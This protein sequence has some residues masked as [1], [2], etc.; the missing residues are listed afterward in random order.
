MQLVSF[1]EDG[2]HSIRDILAARHLEVQPNSLHSCI[3]QICVR[4]CGH[5]R[6]HIGTIRRRLGFPFL[7]GLSVAIFAFPFRSSFYDFPLRR[8]VSVVFVWSKNRRTL[9]NF[10][11]WVAKKN[12]SRKKPNTRKGSATP[13]ARADLEQELIALR[14]K[15]AFRDEMLARAASAEYLEKSVIDIMNRL[16]TYMKSFIDNIPGK[17]QD[18]GEG[19]SATAANTTGAVNKTNTKAEHQDLDIRFLD[20]V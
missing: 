10:H 5:L 1:D 19:S 11:Q 12:Y 8:S 4:V 14:E 16:K 6:C 3:V 2:A 15:K 17:Q 13:S 20:D 7:V 9:Q 18:N